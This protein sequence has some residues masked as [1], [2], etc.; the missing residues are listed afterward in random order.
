MCVCVC[1]SDQV[2]PVC[3]EVLSDRRPLQPEHARITGYWTL[4]L[5]FLW[6]E[7]RLTD[8]VGLLPSPPTVATTAAIAAISGDGSDLSI[9]EYVF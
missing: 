3:R 2:L 1:V 9:I 7:N 6:S 8:A 5:Y 4:S